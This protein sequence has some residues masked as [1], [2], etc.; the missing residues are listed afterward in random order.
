LKNS[1]E[2]KRQCK[3]K[4]LFKTFL[5][6][7]KKIK[8]RFNS[9]QITL[10]FLIG[11]LMYLSHL[12]MGAEATESREPRGRIFGKAVQRTSLLDTMSLSFAGNFDFS[13]IFEGVKKIFEGIATC[14]FLIN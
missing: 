4:L 9:C 8:M 11:A 5:N 13:Q 2:K 14:K 7:D 12:T 3:I 1:E 6:V 10:I